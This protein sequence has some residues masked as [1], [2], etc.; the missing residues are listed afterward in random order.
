MDEVF[1]HVLEVYDSYEDVIKL[2]KARGCHLWIIQ[3]RFLLN[4]EQFS[5]YCNNV[6]SK[7]NADILLT[8]ELLD[9]PDSYYRLSKLAWMEF[10]IQCYRAFVLNCCF[11]DCACP[12]TKNRDV[13]KVLIE[14]YNKHIGEQ[15]F[16]FRG[17][18]KSIKT[19][20]NLTTDMSDGI[21]IIS[22]LLHYCP[23]MRKHFKCFAE[24]EGSNEVEG[25]IINNTCLIDDAL[26]HIRILFPLT[27]SDFLE[28]SFVPMLFLSI[29]LYIVLPMFYPRDIIRFKPPLL[30]SSARLVTVYPSI[31][32]SLMCSLLL[33]NNK[34]NNF[35]AEKAHFGDYSKKVFVKVKYT[36]N[37]VDGDNAILLVQ[38]TNKSRLFD[39]YVLF[40]LEGQ[41]GAL[42]PLKKCKATGQIYRQNKVEIG[43]MSPFCITATFDVT[44]TEKEPHVPVDFGNDTKRRFFL[45][46][47]N[48][49]ERRVTLNAAQKGLTDE[50]NEHRLLLQMV[51]L[52]SCPAVSYIW[53]R[54]EVGEFYIKVVATARCDI[55][56]D[57]LR[58]SVRTWPLEPCNCGEDCKCYRSTVV[59]IPHRN[60]L[61]I[62][63]M[64][65]ALFEY[66]T[67]DMV[68]VFDRHIRKITLIYSAH[69]ILQVI[70]RG[71]C[72]ST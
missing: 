33:L 13:V 62:R 43:V 45:R 60:E 55:A 41:T 50:E 35:M 1:K 18:N 59:M 48:L 68:A 31:Q 23:F 30:R 69:L 54:S 5:V 36:A 22:V 15:H 66:A 7:T 14:W 29:H 70:Q 64:R 42:Y 46:C 21:A 67:P 38:G 44:I 47:L 11:L 40:L 10:V 8:R 20:A 51:C 57:T 3:A 26:K 39:A 27:Y 16:Y 32:E 72:F 58:A 52:S 56:L 34:K 28:P 65:C 19:I 25:C 24:V 49:T 4:F 71:S 9:D 12:K 37:F 6:T 61:M 63:A 53:F 2:L 17:Q